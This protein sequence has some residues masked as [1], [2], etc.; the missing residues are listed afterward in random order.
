[1]VVL[2]ERKEALTAGGRE[3]IEKWRGSGSL[4]VVTHGANIFA[5][6]GVSPASGEIVVVRGSGRDVV[7]R[8]RLD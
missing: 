1:M 7:G 5:L 6:T 3:V 8:L 4:L 2:P